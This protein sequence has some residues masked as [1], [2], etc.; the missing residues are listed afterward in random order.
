MDPFDDDYDGIVFPAANQNYTNNSF[1]VSVIQDLMHLTNTYRLYSRRSLTE[2]LT[3]IF[4]QFDQPLHSFTDAYF[5][6]GNIFHLEN[7]SSTL[8]ISIEKLISWIGVTRILCGEFDFNCTTEE[9]VQE[10]SFTQPLAI[11]VKLRQ[12]LHLITPEYC[13]HCQTVALFFTDMIE[14]QFFVNHSFKKSNQYAREPID[15]VC[16][17]KK[18]LVFFDPEKHLSKLKSERI[19]ELIGEKKLAL[20][21]DFIEVEKQ[22]IV[23]E[24]I[25]IAFGIKH[26]YI[27]TNGRLFDFSK[28]VDPYFH[29]CLTP[30]MPVFLKSKTFLDIYHFYEMYEWIEIL[31]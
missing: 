20:K 8:A 5:E 30:I 14:E 2:F 4:L 27:H 10:K 17:E 28:S 18:R 21:N 9:Y 12:N 15:F 3:R 31:P 11:N 29:F 13:S 1:E 23:N 6:S 26:G 24:I 25:R 7:E 19:Q 16:F 22:E